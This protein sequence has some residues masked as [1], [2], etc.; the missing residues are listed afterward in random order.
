LRKRQSSIDS[1]GLSATTKHFSDI[2]SVEDAIKRGELFLDLYA[3]PFASVSLVVPDISNDYRSGQRVT[4]IDNYNGVTDQL[5]INSI[6]K[7]FPHKGDVL[8]CG[9]KEYSLANYNKF[10]LD[11]IKRLEE[12]MNKNDDIIIQIL[13]ASQSISY[14]RR[15]CKILKDVVDLA[16]SGIYGHP[17]AGIYGTSEYGVTYSSYNTVTQIVQGDMTYEEYVYDTDFHDA[18]N[19]TATFNTTTK[20]ITFTNGQV[21]YSSVIDLGTT[22]SQIKVDLGTLTGTLLIEISSDNK[23]TWQTVTEGILTAVSSSDGTG[24]YVRLTSTGVSTLD[25]TTNAYGQITEP[26]IKIL[27]VE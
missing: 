4:I 5:V 13:D 11:K 1:Y 10:T 23:S 7:E 12:E 26:N 6:T 8:N 25:R 20:Q 15:Y 19:S 17:T 3:E 22:L 21:W 18:I 27:M 14:K 24:T 9:D 2:K 16:N